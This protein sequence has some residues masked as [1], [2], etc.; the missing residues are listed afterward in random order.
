[1]ERGKCGQFCTDP[2]RYRAH[3]RSIEPLLQGSG[4][5]VTIEVSLGSSIAN[6][7]PQERKRPMPAGRAVQ[8]KL[9][10]PEWQVS[11]FMMDRALEAVERQISRLDRSHDIPYLAGYSRNGKTI[12]IDRHMPKSF[13]FKGRRI[14]TDRFLILHE[15]VEKTLMD[16]L[17]LRYL[18]A[19]QIA[20]RAEQA[21]VRAAGI[22][23]DAYDR[24][25][26]IYVKSIGDKRLGK[27][28]RDLDLKPY[29]DE[30]DTAVLRRIAAALDKGPMRMGFR[31][32]RVRD[33]RKRPAK[34]NSAT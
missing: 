25:M 18:H 28:P 21:A 3:A 1:M 12:Y 9:R 6:E 19:H 20:T 8:K 27:V 13:S 32:Y 24:F 14:K 16:H 34:K 23:W 33:R 30:H 10:A 22:S 29:R 4:D 15:A 11:S 17:G 7:R 2:R 26:R 5:G 31:A